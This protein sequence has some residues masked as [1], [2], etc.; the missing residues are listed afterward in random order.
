M[1]DKQEF[2]ALTQRLVSGLL[3]E[4]IGYSVEY[5]VPYY[6]GIV[7]YLV[8]APMLWIRHSHFPIFFIA[9]DR[10]RPDVLAD[11]VKQLEIAK[12]TEYFA[13]LIV[14]PTREGTGNEA[15]E[16]RHIVA[17]SVYCHDFVVLDRQHLA[18]IIAQNSPKRLI[19]IILEQGIELSSLSPYVVIGPVPE[20]MFFGR[21]KE[22]KAISQ[23]IRRGNYAVV[24]G[25]R[26]GKSSM[27]QKLTRLFNRNPRYRAIYLDCEE[28]FDYEDLF[29]VLGDELG[30]PLDS[31]DPLDF[32]RLA[33]TLKEEAPTRQVV[34]LLDEV[35]ELL[36]FDA[37]SKPAGQLFKVFRSLS[38]EGTC[39]FVFSGG[40]TLYRHLHDA[41]SP[42]FNFCK[43]IVLG[44][45]A[46][47]SVAEIIS[48]PMHQLGI[49]LS[50]E[51]ALIDRIIDLTSCHPSLV[52]WLCDKLVKTI[53]VRRITLDDLEAVSTNPDF[54]QHFIETAWGTAAPLERLITLLVEGPIFELDQLLEAL[55]HYGITDR[56]M[57]RDALEMLQMNAL[58]DRRGQQYRFVL[59]HFPR[60]VREFEDIPTLIETLLTQV[61]A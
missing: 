58:L 60:I 30:Q 25:R 23:T 40:R 2:V 24:G 8:E 26:I 9:Y 6:K 56:P 59:S 41:K 29:K 4:A 35:D 14:V 61:E 37:Q 34:F 33:I 13:L 1:I 46:E 17:D 15:E 39:R 51:E 31:S 36:A 49:E 10:R 57:I 16:L 55:A 20:N 27:L 7:G 3:R 50:E 42:F 38:Q 21:E 5:Q 52:Q 19:E 47:K 43:D 45:L 32:R 11:V 22:I 44:P 28:K 54:Y 48:K 12:A 53:S 18:S